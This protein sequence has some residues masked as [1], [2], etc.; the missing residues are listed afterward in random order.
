MVTVAYE[1]ADRD[2]AKQALDALVK[3]GTVTGELEIKPM[4]TGHW[5]LKIHSEGDV[6]DSNVEK[7]G[8]R[9]LD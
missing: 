6:K 4:D 8:G 2:T 1:F 3:N 9:K 5:V 7:L